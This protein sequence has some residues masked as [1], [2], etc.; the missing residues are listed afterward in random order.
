MTDYWRPE[1]LDDLRSFVDN[2]LARESRRIEF[3]REL[4]GNRAFAR[5]LAAFAIEGGSIVIGVAEEA[6]NQFSV[7]PIPVAGLRERVEQIAQSVVEPPLWVESRILADDD[8]KHGVLWV[9]VPQ[10]P[11][12]LHQ[13]DGTYYERGDTQVRP[14]SDAA[15]ERLMRSRSSSLD[16]IS[17]RLR[18]GLLENPIPHGI[19]HT[20]IVAKP[21]GAAPQEFYDASGGQP[22]WQALARDLK[23]AQP[24]G[25]GDLS[26]LKWR[27][28]PGTSWGTTTTPAYTEDPRAY[29]RLAL[30]DDGAFSILT[31][32]HARDSEHLQ[33]GLAIAACLDAVAVAGFVE[34]KI[35]RRFWDLAIGI[36][37]TKDRKAVTL[38][39]LALV[40][41]LPI[42]N[43][44]YER[45]LRIPSIR[46]ESDPWGIA[47]DLTQRFVEGCGLRFETEATVLGYSRGQQSRC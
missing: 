6:D 36:T 33:P 22:E 18:E 46:I 37:K 47:R 20:Y 7:A 21:I 28:A 24:A 38:H 27:Y 19:G 10:S 35:G 11:D 16:D 43:D 15:V 5:Q 3:K 4:P 14:M 17:A 30:G 45:A 29:F 39:S 1:T 32:S 44:E 34:T 9:D 26:R 25:Q 41:D 8:G 13:V 40:S 31:Y 42:P 2:G 12:A 23:Q